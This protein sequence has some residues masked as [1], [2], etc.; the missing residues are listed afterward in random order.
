MKLEIE[1]Y[2]KLIT[3]SGNEFIFK[4][5]KQVENGWIIE[6]IRSNNLKS[7]GITN[8]FLATYSSGETLKQDDVVQMS[9]GQMLAIRL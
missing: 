8:G 1:C 7:S 9:D 3:H 6:I 5:V 2:Y 4:T